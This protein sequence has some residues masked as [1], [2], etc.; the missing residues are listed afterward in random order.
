[1]ANTVSKKVITG[2]NTRFSYLNA[3]EPKTMSDGGTPKYSVSL[4]IRK[5]DKATVDAIRAAIKFVYENNPSTLQ[6]SQ[7]M[8]PALSSMKTPLRDGD[9]ERP[10]DPAYKGCYFV[11]ANSTEKPGIVDGDCNP[12]LDRSEVYSGCYGRASVNFYPYN[13]NGNKGIAAGLNN[14]Q[15]L[16]D[17]TPLS[18]RASAADDFA[19]ADYGDESF[20]G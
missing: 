8:L 12:I 15:K 18:G 4:I 16:K 10:G 9:A 13:R 20:L 11:N 19:T 7:K 17:G 2:P 6:G 1:M 14:L 5:D 3:F